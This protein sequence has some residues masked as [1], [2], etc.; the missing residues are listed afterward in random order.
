[1]KRNKQ[2]YSNGIQKRRG[3]NQIIPILF[4]TK[5]EKKQIVPKLFKIEVEQTKVVKRIEVEQKDLFPKLIQMAIKNLD[6]DHQKMYTRK[7]C[8]NTASF[9]L[10]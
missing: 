7:A 8:T 6:G 3:T 9:Q 2:R 10:A 5:M 4:R 1:M